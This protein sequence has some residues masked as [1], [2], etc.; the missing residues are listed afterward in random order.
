MSEEPMRTLLV[1]LCRAVGPDPGAVPDAQLLRRFVAARDAAAF[2]TLVWRHG[3]MVLAACRRVLRQEQD[4]EDAFQAT[5]L[6]LAR[7]AGT[8]GRGEAVAG[9]LY[10]VACRAALHLRAT[11]ARRPVPDESA[12]LAAA[13]PPEPDPAWADLR[14]VLDEE[15]SRLP[16]PYREAFVLCCLEGLTAA[17]AARQLGCPPGTVQS[18]LA[19]ARLRLRVRLTGRGVGLT[20]GALAVALA[21]AVAPA[22]PPALVRLAARAGGC[23]LAGQGLAG[24]L[25]ARVLELT[26]GVLRAMSLIRLKIAAAACLVALTLTTAAGVAGYHGLAAPAPLAGASPESAKP[27]PPKADPVKPDPPKAEAAKADAVLAQPAVLPLAGHKG[28][29]RAVAF[30]RDGKSV[31]TAGADKTVRVWDLATSREIHKLELP[32]EGAGVAFAPDDKMLVAAAT[33]K[34]G[35]VIAW[36]ASNGK[37]LSATRQL[38]GAD[39]VAFAP[40]GQQVVVVSQTDIG[41]IYAPKTGA[42]SAVFKFP[43]GA[44]PAAAAISPDGKYLALGGAGRVHLCDATNCALLREW[45][46]KGAMVALAF[47]PGGTKVAV[48]DGGKAVR[49]LDVAGGKEETAFAGKA[50]ILAFALSGDGKRAATVQKGGDV[51]LWDAASGKEERRFAAPKGAVSALAFSADGKRLAAAGEEGAVVWD[52]TRDEKLLPRDFKLADKD[53]P[54]L[55]ADLASDD[56][57]KAYAAARMLR[58]DPARSVPY[59]QE[60]LKPKG[61]GPDEKKVKQLI[62]DLDADEF[63]TREKATQELKKLGKTAESALRQALAGKPSAEVARRLEELLKA[64][65][66]AAALTAEQQRDVR[67]VR[68]LEQAGTPEA[69]KL[70]EALK[71]SPG[72]WVAQEAKEALER[73]ERR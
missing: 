51:L 73:L 10:R 36:D 61:E 67:A 28:A 20:A 71:D 52:L 2:E 32:D 7:K 18:R 22:A 33:G 58:A 60:R 39:A 46:G 38:G 30:S 26:E 34:A 43:R 4:A 23:H 62:A 47:L 72:W 35:A 3:P 54:A 8:V 65:G 66:G 31:A 13:A 57:G 40:D 27:E 42:M 70:L 1:R 48:A 25:P 53:L 37:L 11:R 56:G 49:V 24:V 12:L 21:S 29:V 16:R 14:P 9:W 15:V 6:A 41:A 68:V 50:A 5:F 19:R 44:G 59:L 69:K 17:E 63:D 55:W 64:L 45:P